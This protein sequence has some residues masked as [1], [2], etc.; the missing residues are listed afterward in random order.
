LLDPLDDCRHSL[1]AAEYL[2]AAPAEE[3]S[4]SLPLEAL[5]DCEGRNGDATVRLQS[6]G[7]V[8]V[9]W[10]DA[11]RTHTREY[12]GGMDV[13]KLPAWPASEATNG[14]ELLA[15][16]D[17]VSQS[18]ATDGVRFALNRIM[19]RG[20]KGEVVATDGKQLLIEGGFTFPWVGDLLVPRTGVFGAQELPRDG[21]VRVALGDGRVLLRVGNWTFSLKIAEGERYPN[22]DAVIPPRTAAVTRWELGPG[23]ADGLAKMLPNLPGDSSEC[24]SVT[25][26]LGAAVVLR[27]REAGQ[28]R[29]T[30]TTLAGSS[31]EG[32]PVRFATDRRLLARACALGFDTFAVAGA[33]KPVVCRDG[34]R[35]FVWM[36]LD[37]RDVLPP[38]ARPS[39]VGLSGVSRPPEQVIPISRERER[40]ATRP[41]ARRSV[42]LANRDVGRPRPVG[43]L[44]RLS[45]FAEQFRRLAGL[46]AEQRQRER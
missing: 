28:E 43:W 2:H 19:L 21:P 40:R 4:R 33:G 38:H 10:T 20:K 16:L 24:A 26:D 11:G 14:S 8:E 23:G 25:V 45:L 35:T 46:V 9:T 6:D 7:R 13:P 29:S 18:A 39:G 1:L 37:A 31:I 41:A 42:A 32:K 12:P 15:A 5:A 34:K 27:A 22:V 17:R 44:G 30:D 36:T 3:A